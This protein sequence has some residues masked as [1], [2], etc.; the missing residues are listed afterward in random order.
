MPTSDQMPRQFDYIVAGGGSAGSIVAS[1]LS[2]N[3]KNQVLLLEAGP[4]DRSL[5]SR[6]PLGFG[7]ILFND[8]YIWQDYKTSAE[9]GL[10]GRSFQ[11][12][13]GKL[14]G[15]SG[16]INGLI[17]VRGTKDD[18]RAW[19]AAGAEG[20]GWDDVLPFHKKYENSYRGGTELHGTTGPIVIESAR[21]KT[22]LAD[23][24]I[25]TA[26]RVLG[27]GTDVDF[28]SG[29]PEGI[30]LLGCRD[31]QRRSFLHLPDHPQGGS[32]ALQPHRRDPGIRHED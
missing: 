6:I 14:I 31:R 16:A 20:W 22:P 30:R 18:Y 10:K 9:P 25:E 2:E 17:H 3:P 26:A 4:E 12:P 5:W 8:K 21:W 27:T 23:A 15:G 11:L 24:Y 19:V 1:R 28:N 29:S 7:L 13:A 32:Q